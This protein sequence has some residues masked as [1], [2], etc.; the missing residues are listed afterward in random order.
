MNA[1]FNIR[2]MLLTLVVVLFI[3]PQAALAFEFGQPSI[4][5]RG[6]YSWKTGLD[7]IDSDAEVAVSQFGA[8]FTWPFQLSD[9]IDLMLEVA[10]DR[11]QFD[12]ENSEDIAFSNGSRP[13]SRLH[14]VGADLILK[15]RFNQRWTGLTGLGLGVGWEDEISDALSFKAIL[16]ADYRF[17][18]NWNINF[19]LASGETPVGGFFGPFGSIGWRQERS[20][21]FQPGWYGKLQFPPFLEIGYGIN[22]RW[23]MRGFFG[24]FGG[25]FRLADD[26]EASPSGYFHPTVDMIGLYVDYR[27]LPSL[28]FSLGAKYSTY[29]EWEILDDDGNTIQTLE[30][31]NTPSVELKISYVF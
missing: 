18:S 16:G 25:L 3:P 14:S 30:L 17:G 22:D 21:K 10:A 19:G 2:S 15:Y 8:D 24:V 12:W 13:W 28:V 6:S 29:T 4:S 1:K 11:F 31:D 7:D 9:R 27:P 20:Q 5:A 26:N 23:R